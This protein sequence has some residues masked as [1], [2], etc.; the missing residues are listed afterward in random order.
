MPLSVFCNSN[1]VRFFFT[2]VNRLG[3]C[4]NDIEF[5]DKRFKG[6]IKNQRKRI[7]FFTGGT[8]LVESGPLSAVSG[9]MHRRKQQGM[10][11]EGGGRYSESGERKSDDP[12]AME[13]PSMIEFQ[14][15]AE[16]AALRDNMRSA[17]AAI[18]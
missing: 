3:F 5:I 7:R 4:E 15:T 16:I 13:S 17:T 10:W 8:Q 11:G 9:G 2:G 12:D 1:E 14:Y 6:R 18:S